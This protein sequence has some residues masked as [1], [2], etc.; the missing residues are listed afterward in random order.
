MSNLK[1]NVKASRE[2]DIL[3]HELLS[4]QTGLKTSTI[5]VPQDIAES[6]K[7]MKTILLTIKNIFVL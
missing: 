1:N 2:L 4:V 6:I 7:A 3:I 5:E